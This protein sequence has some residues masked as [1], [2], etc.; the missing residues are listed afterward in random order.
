MTSIVIDGIIKDWGER[1]YYSPVV[2][3]KGKNIRSGGRVVKARPA[4]VSSSSAIRA[5]IARTVKKTPEVMVKISGGGKNMQ[6]IKAHMDYISRNGDIELEDENG[7]IHIG[8]EAVRDVRDSWAK[9]KIG[10]PYEGEKRK[11]AFNIIL[12]MPAGTDRR[13]VTNA[14]RLFAKELF[15]NH[16]YVFAEHTNEKHSHVHL[17]V[18]A[19]DHDGVR[20]N[21]RKGD[22]QFWREQFAEKLREQGIEANATPRKARGIVQKAEKQAIVHID[23]DFENGKRKEPSLIAQQRLKEAEREV[24]T[25]IK[26]INPAQDKISVARN[27]MFSAYENIARGLGPGDISDKQLALDI[28]R[29]VQTMPAPI[30]K[31]QA[32]VQ[33]LQVVSGG[34]DKDH[35][36]LKD[37][38]VGNMEK[39][40]DEKIR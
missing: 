25:G 40:N 6:H 36:K 9:G 22:L 29:F 18:K 32:L 20:M 34:K 13:S 21:P 23:K 7:D 12:S 3:S 16:Q 10:I 28:V 30:T 26:R 24:Y 2:G 38:D 14:A 8:K 4:P 39:T 1:L 15:G 37:E 35:S 17:T 5:K 33:S 19:V 31:H 11:E 27:D